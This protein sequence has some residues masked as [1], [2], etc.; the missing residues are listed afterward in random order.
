MVY[1]I[2]LIEGDQGIS[3]PEV[4]DNV[5]YVDFILGLCGKFFS[6]ESY[7]FIDCCE[8]YCRLHVDSIH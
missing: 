8:F 4:D 6:E 3:H 1:V 7:H 5:I 2:L